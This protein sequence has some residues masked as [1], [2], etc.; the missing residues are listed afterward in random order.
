MA[1]V[2]ARTAKTWAQGPAER[3]AAAPRRRNRVCLQ[4][5]PVGADRRVQGGVQGPQDA[6]SQ[7]RAHWAVSQ[8]CRAGDAGLR[9]RDHVRQGRRSMANRSEERRG[10]DVCGIWRENG[11]RASGRRGV[12]SALW[13]S[14]QHHSRAGNNG[15]WPRR[16]GD[17]GRRRR[18]GRRAKSQGDVPPGDRVGEGTWTWQHTRRSRRQAAPEQNA[19][20]AVAA[21]HP[22]R[23]SRG[24][25]TPATDASGRL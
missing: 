2:S 3:T 12:W 16:D 20:T 8:D 25:R 17:R 6:Q 15:R 7:A 5:G 19:A 4:A 13:R 11:R 10:R 14:W 1:G 9:R 23:R 18:L 22:V 24:G 21:S